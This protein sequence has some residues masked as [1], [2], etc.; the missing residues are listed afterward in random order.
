MTKEQTKLSEGPMSGPTSGSVKNLIWIALAYLL[1]IALA[2][3]MTV[4]QSPRT[5][6]V[7]YFG[8]MILLYVHVVIQ[9]EQPGDKFLLVLALAP[10]IRVIG[11][12][13]LPDFVALIYRLFAASIPLFVVAYLLIRRFDLPWPEGSLSPQGWRL[14][15]LIGLSGLL[16]GVIAH[17][18]IGPGTI[19]KPLTG[20]MLLFAV[21]VLFVSS[22]LLEELIFRG[23]IQRM[24]I[25]VMGRWPGVI[26]VAILSSV[27]LFAHRSPAYLLF[28]FAVNLFFGWIVSRTQ[29]ILGVVLAH[30]LTNIVLY[31]IPGCV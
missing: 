13:I 10:M 1:L 18:V 7:L 21:P 17:L 15:L 5:G 6:A 24:A 29:S 4:L 31:L 2:E 9:W 8:I 19:E 12:T 11:L 22:G 14:Q 28:G 16:I 23:L 20:Q 27:F 26:Y 30:G 3:A 25:D